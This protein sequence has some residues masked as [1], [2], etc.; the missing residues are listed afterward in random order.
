[1]ASAKRWNSL[2]L[3]VNTNVR[4]NDSTSYLLSPEMSASPTQ[5]SL[6]SSYS[7]AHCPATLPNRNTYVS[8]NNETLQN[9]SMGSIAPLI[10]NG[11]PHMVSL[12]HSG[13]SNFMYGMFER[14]ADYFF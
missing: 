2:G 1:M 5:F 4:R 14:K 13:Q 9:S 3:R 12:D 8:M 6:S 10:M 11:Q 7:Y